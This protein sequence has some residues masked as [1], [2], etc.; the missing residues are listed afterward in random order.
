MH[1]TESLYKEL[2][3]KIESLVAF[4]REND[5]E[6]TKIN[7]ESL[8]DFTL[9]NVS[10]NKGDVALE[11]FLYVFDGKNIKSQE[12]KTELLNKEIPIKVSSADKLAPDF[13]DES[14]IE[15]VSENNIKIN[16]SLSDDYINDNNKAIL[17][18]CANE[19]LNK[20]SEANLTINY[21][22]EDRY[23]KKVI[24]EILKENKL[25]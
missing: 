4:M 1:K 23:Q 14:K 16:E 19:E 13:K 22:E 18:E 17:D 25:I 9:C 2:K 6:S 5:L 24:A 3:D 8:S 10:Y 11:E 20:D 7:I 15:I 12:Y 21:K